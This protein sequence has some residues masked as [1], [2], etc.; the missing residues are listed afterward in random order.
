M[1]KVTLMVAV[2]M[3]SLASL[4]QHETYV[5]PAL[6]EKL[7]KA[8]PYYFYLDTA[9]YKVM[10]RDEMLPIENYKGKTRYVLEGFKTGELVIQKVK[11]KKKKR[12]RIADTS[13]YLNKQLI[14]H[15]PQTLVYLNGTSSGVQYRIS[16]SNKSKYELIAYI[17]GGNYDKSLLIESAEVRFLRDGEWEQYHFEQ[18]NVIPNNIMNA[19][20]SSGAE[21]LSIQMQ[22]KWKEG[23]LIS[24]KTVDFYF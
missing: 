20:L 16:S 8:L 1:K 12:I 9:I 17:D 22:F 7:Y 6:N 18:T 14:F 15:D 21:K 4:A 19:F 11:Y 2:S 5:L 13:T 23:D 3:L 10:Y 24:S